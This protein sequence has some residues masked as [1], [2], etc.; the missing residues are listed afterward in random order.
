M[1]I[2]VRG[3]FYRQFERQLK[4]AA[5]NARFIPFEDRAEMLELL[6]KAD[7]LYGGSPREDM[8]D[9]CAKL[10]WIH[11]RS[12]GVDRYFPQELA[13]RGI[14]LTNGSGAYDIPIAEHVFAMALALT[15]R[16]HL[17]ICNQ[18]EKRWE[19]GETPADLYGKNLGIYGMGSIGTRVAQIGAAFGMKAYGVARRERSK[20]DFAEALW[21]PERLD[22]LLGMSD[23][24][25]VCLP[26]TNA[27]RNCV[28]A[29]EFGLMKP[30]ALFFNIGRGATVNAA[31]LT[32]ALTEGQIA[33]AGL[34]VT[35]PEPLPVESPLWNMPNVVLTPHVSGSSAVSAARGEEIAIEN[36]RRFA[37]GEPLLN[38]VDPQHGY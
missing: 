17:Y 34:D 23:L 8:L 35:N 7:A 11:M 14:A 36:I 37:A 19:R 26:L 31:A 29:R 10:R 6:P 28:G 38:V 12:A 9:R 25:V 16:I 18:I 22:D 33:G 3:A 30:T 2:L 32:R 1:N 4:E 13:K 15:R 24:F 27:T 20:P 21:T 5:P